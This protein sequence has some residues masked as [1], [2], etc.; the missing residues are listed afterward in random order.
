VTPLPAIG[1]WGPFFAVESHGAGTVPPAPWRPLRDLLDDPD[2]LRERVSGVRDYLAAG[3]PPEAV[4]VRVAAS[5]A[6]LGLVARLV[7]PSFGCAV[8][9]GRFLA[10]DDA[11]WRPALGGAFPLSVSASFVDSAD[12][13]FDGWLRGLVDAVRGFSVSE[14]VLWGN[15]ASAVNGASVVVPARW[16]ALARAVAAELLARPQLRD[17]WE[18]PGGRFRRRSCCLIYRAGAGPGGVCGDCVL[19]RIDPV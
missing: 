16:G 3:R 1:R 9:S 17:A 2:V 5:V 15:V 7:S 12:G 13:L 14:R 4:P 8:H 18:R 19:H 11:W 10:L 6:H